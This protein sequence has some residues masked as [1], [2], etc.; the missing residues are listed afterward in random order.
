MMRHSGGPR[1][2]N[3]CHPEKPGIKKAANKKPARRKRS[4]ASRRMVPKTA[5]SRNP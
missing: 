2:T 4:T 5:Q 3:G 1:M